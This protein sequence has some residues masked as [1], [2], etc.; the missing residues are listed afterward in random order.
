MTNQTPIKLF[1]CPNTRSMRAAWALEEVGAKYDYVKLDLRKGEGRSTHFLAVNPGGKVPTLVDD[2]VVISESG[3]IVTYIGE[4]FPGSGL[5]PPLSQPASRAANFEWCFFVLSE[6]EQPLWTIAK[7]RFALPPDWRVQSIE[8][9][10][11]KEFQRAIDVAATRLGDR[12]FTVGAHFT[13]ADILLSHTI[14]WAKSA[15]IAFAAP[16]LDKFFAR[17]WAR[18]ARLQA[19]ARE[20]G[21]I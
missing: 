21:E 1:G 6:L 10:A 17:H 14:S 18:P 5:V 8:A 11:V 15:N 16:A 9:T 4:R 19:D 7:H 12:E 3:A 20:R 2:A 13:A